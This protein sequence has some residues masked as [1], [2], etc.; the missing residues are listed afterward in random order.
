MDQKAK[1]TNTL[2][3]FLIASGFSFGCLLG[4]IVSFSHNPDLAYKMVGMAISVFVIANIYLFKR[5]KKV[6]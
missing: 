2:I 3:F 1:N 6:S 4:A 5:F